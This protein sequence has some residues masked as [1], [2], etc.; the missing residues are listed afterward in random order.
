MEAGKVEGIREHHLNA[1]RPI[2]PIKSETRRTAVELT[3]AVGAAAPREKAGLE[4][5]A[6]E[7]RSCQH[8]LLRTRDVDR[9]L[10]QPRE[11]MHRR[12]SPRRRLRRKRTQKSRGID[13]DEAARNTQHTR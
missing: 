5:D 9:R 10:V 8:L 6:R 4:K 1:G 2:R 7:I 13:R 12:R 3:V 11:W